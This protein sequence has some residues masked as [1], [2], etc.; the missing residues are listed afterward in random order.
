MTTDLLKQSKKLQSLY[1]R[2]V[3]KPRTCQEYIKYIKFRAYY[4]STKRQTKYN[5]F[6]TLLSEY[7]ADIRKTWRVL[8]VITGRAND[9]TSCTDA[10]KVNG[11]PITN[12]TDIANGFCTYFAN[13]EKQYAEDIPLSRKTSKSYL[14]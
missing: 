11:N 9:K 2:Y 7:Q 5:Y 10:F 6:E 14:I 8:N 12:K 3:G 1:H 4:N 13:I